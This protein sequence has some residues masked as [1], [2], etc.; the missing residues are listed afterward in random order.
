MLFLFVTLS[1]T[2]IIVNGAFLSP[3]KDPYSELLSCKNFGIFAGEN[4]AQTCEA[5]CAPNGTESFDYADSEEDPQYVVRN[6]V[7]RCFEIGASGQTTINAEADKSFE[8]WSK[9]EVWDK[10]TPIMKCEDPALNITGQ[11]ECE[12]FCQS[13]D[14][15][16]WGYVTKKGKSRCSCHDIMVCD[17]IG[18]A[19]VMPTA[20]AFTLLLGTFVMLW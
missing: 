16:A 20:T 11:T 5:Y 2:T 4:M 17:D 8:C 14:P 10:Q 1:L 13:I 19:T 7:C 15:L 12:A 18:S 3:I 9:A 6:T